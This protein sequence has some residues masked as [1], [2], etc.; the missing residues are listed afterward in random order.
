MRHRGPAV[1]SAHQSLPRLTTA[2]LFGVQCDTMGAG[3]ARMV[4]A[5]E[6][7]SSA[8]LRYAAVISSRAS[9]TGASFSIVA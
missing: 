2:R 6:D 4:G 7:K 1:R 3:A 5:D 9:H 8:L